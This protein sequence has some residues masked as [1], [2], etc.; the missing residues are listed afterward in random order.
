MSN[1][2]AKTHPKLQTHFHSMEQQLE[3]S[4]LGMWVFLVTEVMFFGG[5]FAAY[6]V[7][8][9]MYPE[10]WV[11]AN[12]RPAYASPEGLGQ[13]FNFDLL[14]QPFDR[15]K[16]FQEMR[17]RGGPFGGRGGAFRIEHT[18]LKFYPAVVHAQSP[19]AVALQLHG[20][21]TA[22]DITPMR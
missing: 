22:E 15:D 17:Q 4:T 3:A 7:Y 21:I 6:M 2:T 18:H 13:A 11:H 9:N 16:F 5:L 19:V 1:A 20:R 8:R 14:V 10:A 12:R